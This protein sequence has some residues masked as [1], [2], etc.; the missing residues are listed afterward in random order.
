MT[1]RRL[2]AGVLGLLATGCSNAGP[3]LADAGADSGGMAESASAC[4]AGRRRGGSGSCVVDYPDACKLDGL[5][6]SPY[7]QG[8]SP[9]TGAFVGVGQIRGRLELIADLT[10]AIRTYSTTGGLEVTC[11]IARELGLGFAQGIWL[12]ADRAGN[13]REIDAF[14]RIASTC[15]MDTVI[16]GNEALWRK[17]LTVDEVVALIGRVRSMAPAGVRLTTAE[18]W[19]TWL[20]SPSLVAAVDVIYMH[21]Y[22]F[23]DGRPIASA[24]ADLEASWNQVVAV[25]G[26]K[27]VIIAETGWPSA[28][29]PLDQAVPSSANAAA[30]FLDFLR[31]S[32]GAGTGYF[33]FSAFDEDWKLA[34]GDGSVGA[35]WGILD[36]DGV[37]KR[38]VQ[39][40][41][42]RECGP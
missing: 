34:D 42:A 24:L 21:A 12:G 41:L 23:W 11:A 39:D 40:L 5:A 27:P 7:T 20:D 22:P 15:Q 2:V 36:R 8:Q 18:V 33:Y 32:R 37:A 13:E 35:S 3:G 19:K 4:P 25:A 1:E 9:L 6:F 14:G 17:D 16:V 10:R 26:G 28:G 29:M 30:Y 31:W 38:G